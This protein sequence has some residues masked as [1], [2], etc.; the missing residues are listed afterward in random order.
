MLSSPFWPYNNSCLSRVSNL[1]SSV[2]ISSSYTIRNSIFKFMTIEHMALDSGWEYN[3][4]VVIS[5][6]PFM[7]SSLRY[8]TS[9]YIYFFFSFSSINIFSMKQHASLIHLQNIY[10]QMGSTMKRSVFDEQTSKALEQ[11]HKKARRKNE[12]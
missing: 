2:C 11:W 6:Y 5:H 8:A 12:K 3:S 7:L 4:Y 10:L 9:I 1:F